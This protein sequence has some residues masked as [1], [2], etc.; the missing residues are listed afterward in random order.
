MTQDR[1][2]DFAIKIATVNGTG[3]ASANGL[4]SMVSNVAAL[5]DTDPDNYASMTAV[6]DILGLLGTSYVGVHAVQPQP[7]GHVTG[8]LVSEPGQLLNLG[9]LSGVTVQTLQGSTVSETFTAGSTLSLSV[10]GGAG[11]P[12]L[13]SFTPTKPY[14]AV[15]VNIGGAVGVLG[16]L[17]VH[18]ACTAL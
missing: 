4:L 7:A 8:F 1:T 13:L 11:E 15:R 16:S 18:A 9:L 14:D 10:L 6:A 3:S 12:G 2:N 17:R 5:T